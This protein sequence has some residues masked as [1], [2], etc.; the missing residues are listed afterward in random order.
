MDKGC[1]NLEN[2]TFHQTLGHYDINMEDSPR[3]MMR[4]FYKSSIKQTLKTLFVGDGGCPSEKSFTHIVNFQHLEEL[5]IADDQIDF[6][7]VGLKAIARLSSLQSADIS[8][9]SQLTD[10]EIMAVLKKN[11]F[12]KSSNN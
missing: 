2:F 6:T 12:F 9:G 11:R 4:D 1:K 5:T 7:V 10:R 8:C 3:A